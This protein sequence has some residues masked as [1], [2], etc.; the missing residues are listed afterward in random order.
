MQQQR[1]RVNIDDYWSTVAERFNGPDIRP[2]LDV[3]F[4]LRLENL[5]PSSA[6]PSPLSGLKLKTVWTDMRGPFT[7]A[8]NDFKKSAQ[9]NPTL[10]GTLRFL[11]NKGNGQLS[12]LSK[13]ILIMFIVLRIGTDNQGTD[14]QGSTAKSMLRK[15]LTVI[16]GGEGFVEAGSQIPPNICGAGVGA[17]GSSSDDEHESCSGYG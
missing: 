16:S 5:D 3:H 15:A 12:A 13:R 9:N 2:R 10:L 7:K 11:K 14:D 1:N 4:E 8:H 6:P 17:A